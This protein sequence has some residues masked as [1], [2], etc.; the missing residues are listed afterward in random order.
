[1]GAPLHDSE[2]RSR[3][4]NTSGNPIRTRWRTYL[5]S[6]TITAGNPSD[7]NGRAA[8]RKSRQSHGTQLHVENAPSA[9][10][11]PYRSRAPGPNFAGKNSSR[12]NVARLLHFSRARV[13]PKLCGLPR[14]KCS[15]LAKLGLRTKNASCSRGTAP[16][17]CI[18]ACFGPCFGPIHEF[19]FQLVAT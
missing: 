13:A 3:F 11:V 12:L 6:H 2:A 18:G 9:H 17:A 7:R 14:K 5:P 19:K 15:S 1:M 10:S 16:T 8:L 4:L